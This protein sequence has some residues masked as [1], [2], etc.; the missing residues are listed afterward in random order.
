MQGCRHSRYL[1]VQVQMEK[2]QFRSLVSKFLVYR[3]Q[4][5]AKQGFI[6]ESLYHTTAI[7]ARWEVRCLLIKQEAIWVVCE[8][9]PST[10]Y[11]DLS[12]GDGRNR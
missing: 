1:F 4:T 6:L 5:I 10:G 9:K 8:E 12:N 7:N 11:C 2:D 3:N